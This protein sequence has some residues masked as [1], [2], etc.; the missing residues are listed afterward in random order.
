MNYW[1]RFKTDNPYQRLLA[2]E[3]LENLES[4]RLV[5]FY[6]K[7]SM[8]GDENYKA[9]VS[10]YRQNMSY[11]NYG[12]ETLAMAVE[13]TRYEILAKWYCS[14]NM[15]VF[16][17]ELKIKELLKAGK[18]FP[19]LILLAAIVENKFVSVDELKRLSL[20][21]NLQAAQVQL[22]QTLNSVQNQLVSNLTNHQTTLVSQLEQRMKQLEEGDKEK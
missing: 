2:K 14:Q 5:A 20:I 10:F 3:L 9:E 7:N 6:H 17:P 16:S 8:N 1:N 13:G 11:K 15:I 18:R 12:K 22:V 4:S 19:S 21:P